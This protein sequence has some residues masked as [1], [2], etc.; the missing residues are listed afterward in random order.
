M[1]SQP[2]KFAVNAVRLFLSSTFRDMQGERDIL[3]RIVLPRLRE[4]LA[5]RSVAL[6]E[7]DLR[8]GVTEAMAR[9]L[10]AVPICLREVAACSP[11]V[12]GIVARRVGW[13]P[14]LD[15]VRRF[16][17]MFAQTLP[18]KIGMTEIELRY[19]LHTMRKDSA[20]ASQSPHAFRPSMQ[21]ASVR[22]R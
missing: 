20:R 8:W 15:A 13:L 11:V 18:P 2:Q 10:G 3:A 9:D 6:Q 14:P 19:A 1:F 16:D 22:R 12:I 5:A 17:S 7:V 4:Q 21:G